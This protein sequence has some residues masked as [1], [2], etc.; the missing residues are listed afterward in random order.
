[1]ERRED[2]EGEEDEDTMAM[3]RELDE[4]QSTTSNEPRKEKIDPEFERDVARIR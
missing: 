2:E 3:M 4:A 1:M